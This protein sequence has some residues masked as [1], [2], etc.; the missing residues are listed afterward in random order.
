MFSLQSGEVK[1]KGLQ[2]KIIS[3]GDEKCDIKMIQILCKD[4]Y[5]KAMDLAF[6]E[7]KDFEDILCQKC[8]IINSKICFCCNRMYPYFID[9][10]CEECAS[11]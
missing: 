3:W 9:E 8:K 7:G 4:C 10:I 1:I 11:S 5:Q 2:F 6:R